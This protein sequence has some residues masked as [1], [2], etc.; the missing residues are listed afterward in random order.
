M[1]AECPVLSVAQVYIVVC[2]VMGWKLS[3]VVTKY[4]TGA[5]GH[6]H[7]DGNADPAPSPECGTGEPA[8]IR[9]MSVAVMIL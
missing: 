9:K 6:T 5:Q 4:Q 1:Q 8:M 2:Q 7:K 3:V